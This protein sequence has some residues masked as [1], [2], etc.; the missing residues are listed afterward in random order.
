MHQIE[1][2]LHQHDEHMPLEVEVE[3]K[4]EFKSVE[5]I[6]SDKDEEIE[7]LRRIFSIANSQITFLQ[8]ENFQLKVKQLIQ[9]KTKSELEVDKGEGKKIIDVDQM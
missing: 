3:E 8:Q 5:E 6:I 2:P 7:E 1:S 4:V 9:R